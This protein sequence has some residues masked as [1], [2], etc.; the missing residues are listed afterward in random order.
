MH[1]KSPSDP[2]NVQCK[3]ESYRILGIFNAIHDWKTVGMSLLG[4][5]SFQK[6]DE[7]ILSALESDQERMIKVLHMWHERKGVEATYAVLVQLFESISNHD[8]A[9]A[10]RAF[11]MKESNYHGKY[12]IE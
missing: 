6:I 2:L 4:I 3:K 9:N 10:V 1:N 8:A 12:C 5:E 11:A 7:D